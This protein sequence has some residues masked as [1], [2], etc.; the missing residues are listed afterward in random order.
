MLKNRAFTLIE[1]LVVISIIALLIGIL[2]P[3]LGAA[4]VAAQRMENSTRIRGVSSACIAYADSNRGRYPGMGKDQTT[5][6]TAGTE[7]HTAHRR[8]QI[9]LDGQYF[10]AEYIVS[11][12]EG[13]KTPDSQLSSDPATATDHFSYALLEIEVGAGRQTEWGSTLNSEA[14]VLGDRETAGATGPAARSI[15]SDNDWRG[16]VGYND[17]HVVFETDNVLG[18]ETRFGN[19]SNPTNSDDL[20]VDETGAVA[21]ANALFLFN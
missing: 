4:R 20:F 6:T 21:G 1:L 14:P 12:R 5:Y 16:T 3:T 8:L 10:T 2:L 18:G 11:P 19:I 7:W 15:W 9:L 13:T 17:N